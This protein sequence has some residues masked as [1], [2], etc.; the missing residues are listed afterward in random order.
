MKTILF[1]YLK[2]STLQLNNSEMTTFGQFRSRCYGTKIKGVYRV[3][4]H[5]HIGTYPYFLR[6]FFKIALAT[7]VFQIVSFGKAHTASYF[8]IGKYV[9]SKQII[10]VN[11]NAAAFWEFNLFT[12][13]RYWFTPLVTR[14]H[15]SSKEFS[16]PL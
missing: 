4:F 16:V 15:E 11:S 5:Y 14:P 12:Y 6:R 9:P 13:H 7:T 1:R 2:S 8:V 3:S 10:P